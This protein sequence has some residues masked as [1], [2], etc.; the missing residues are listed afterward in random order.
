LHTEARRFVDAIGAWA[1][2]FPPGVVELVHL[3]IP[4]D[5]DYRLAASLALRPV[6]DGGCPI[7]LGITVPEKN[8]ATCIFIDSW[9]ALAHRHGFAVAASHSKFVALYLEPVRLRLDTVLEVCRQV[10]A[11]AVHLQAVT[12]GR[13]LVGTAGS[14]PY[15]EGRLVMRG[16]GTPLSLARAAAKLRLLRTRRIQYTPW[17]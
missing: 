2:S 17:R 3:P 6:K 14:V 5:D 9:A 15:S 4:E 10:A 16:N 1:S 7:E 13:R 8:S 11:G 12:L